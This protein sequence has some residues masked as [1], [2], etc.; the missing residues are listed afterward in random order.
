VDFLKIDGRCGCGRSSACRPDERGHRPRNAGTSGGP[1]GIALE[2][3]V[4]TVRQVYE[5]T[6]F[7]VLGVISAML[8][9]RRTAARAGGERVQLARAVVVTA[10][11]SGTRPR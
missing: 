9:L 6:V 4:D 8:L 1:S 2:V 3:S 11:R 5:T 7:G 10:V